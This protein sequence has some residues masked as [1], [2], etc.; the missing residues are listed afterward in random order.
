MISSS[1]GMCGGSEGYEK[2]DSMVS[3]HLNDQ[4]YQLKNSFAEVVNVTTIILSGISI[5]TA[6]A[7]CI[8][9]LLSR[10]S[11]HTRTWMH[12]WCLMA[13]VLRTMLDILSDKV[14]YIHI[15]LYNGM[16]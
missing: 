4:D 14:R 13:C 12:L 2:W 3:T 6:I 8:A 15:I 9:T 7:A 5:I 1:I 16:I 10:Q 11:T